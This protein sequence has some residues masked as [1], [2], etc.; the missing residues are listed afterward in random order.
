MHLRPLCGVVV[1]FHP[2]EGV[3]DRLLIVVRECGRVVV[4]DNGSSEEV[5][6]R[7]AEIAGVTVLPLGE[8]MGVATAMNRGLVWAREAG[9]SWVV[10]FDQD[11]R[12]QEGMVSALWSTHEA[13]ASA[14]VVGP[15]IEDVGQASNA[16]RWVRPHPR[17]PGLFQRVPSAGHD[18]AEVTM[19][20]TSG[21]LIEIATWARLGGFDESLFIDYVDTDYCLRVN[22][23]G[24]RVAVAGAAV[25]DHRLGER[26]SKAVLGH[27]FR[28]T[29]HSATRHYFIARNRIPIWRKHALA[30]PHWAAFDAAFAIYNGFR[31]LFFER[32]R[33]R[34]LKA[35]VLGT[36]DGL[37]G[38][39]GPCP[40]KRTAQLS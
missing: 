31:V 26:Q 5:Y 7:M 10:T 3:Y 32:E 23:S 24:R 38:R 36:W 30:V 33:G 2:D 37:G 35:I 1:T 8:N 20:V 16:Y 40:A 28:P 12:P 4:V 18:L 14:A 15:R 25:L 39:S 29:H 9:F 22:R 6:R 27:D 13:L 21:S 11:S 34:K 17:W 19:L